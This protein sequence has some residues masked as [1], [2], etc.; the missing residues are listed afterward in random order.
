MVR[1]KKPEWRREW[2]LLDAKMTVRLL[3]R[4]ALLGFKH[5]IPGEVKG[6]NCACY[7]YKKDR[8]GKEVRVRQQPVL[9]TNGRVN[10]GLWRK[11]VETMRMQ[12][13]RCDKASTCAHAMQQGCRNE[14]SRK[15]D[16]M[17]AEMR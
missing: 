11:P 13:K 17:D 1:L 3:A 12:K 5:G 2:R 16:V 9:S 15:R 8:Y 6:C 4:Y 7:S 14:G 10:R